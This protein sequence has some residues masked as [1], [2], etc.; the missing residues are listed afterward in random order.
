M[1]WKGAREW[2]IERKQWEEEHKAREKVRLGERQLEL[3][4]KRRQAEKEIEDEKKAKAGVRFAN[5]QPEP[6]CLRY[7]TRKWTA[8]LDNV[9]TGFDPILVCRET[10]AHVNGRW[11]L[12]DTCENKV[13][14]SFVSPR[15]HS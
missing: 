14:R 5:P 13:R 1:E 6:Q 11:L 12:P 7:G 3:E 9:P 10:K 8:K 15:V 4:R 2:A